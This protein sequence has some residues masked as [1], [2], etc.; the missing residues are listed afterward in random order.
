MRP[1]TSGYKLPPRMLARKKKLKSGTVWI[2]Y[3]YN[4]RDD[5]GKRKE[6]P[7]GTDLNEAKRKWAELECK[8]VP[9]D[10][11]LM[12]IV[13]EKYIRDILPAKAPATQ[14]E[15]GD[16][17]RQLRAVFD[18]APIDAISPQDIA[19]YRDARSAK[20]RANREITLLSHVFNMAREWGFMK[21]E[22]PC[23]GVRKNKE[24]PRDFYADA[25]V[26]DAVYATAS[27]ELQ[28]AMDLNYLTGQRPADV[29]RMRDSHIRDGAL[30]VR[31]GKTNKF[32]RILL[33]PKGI[34]SQLSA[35]I[36]RIQARPERKPDAYLVTL[37][38]GEPLKQ[39]NLR[40]RFDT[41]RGTAIDC[42]LKAGNSALAERIKKFQF[43]DIRAK[44][45]SEIADVKAASE[46]LGH[47]EGEITDRVYRRVGQAVTP[48]R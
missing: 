16:S 14:R 4:G 12:Q 13:F 30:H 25:E 28:D 37:P 22:N 40:L 43:R 19:R 33:H 3:Y 42:A 29:L 20:V 26:W 39:W 5:Q 1:K 27:T 34:Q 7:L 32:L 18:S 47:T 17:L 31:Q 45:A 44:S 23:R 24:K 41:A 36:D 6:F 38:S 35:V 15:N 21:G 48:T 10:A 2:G 46:L 9:A 8:P 11:T